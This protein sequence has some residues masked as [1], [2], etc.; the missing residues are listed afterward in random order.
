ML[1]RVTGIADNLSANTVITGQNG[2]VSSFNRMS[3]RLNGMPVVYAGNANISSDE[4]L[5]VVGERKGEFFA[6]ALR[7]DST[8]ISYPAPQRFLKGTAILFAIPIVCLVVVFVFLSFSP[9]GD[10]TFLIPAVLLA[11][12]LLFPHWMF[13]LYKRNKQANELLAA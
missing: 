9:Q 3:F 8:G 12:V 7:N 2:N 11:L 6:Y 5:T 1:E 4:T 13:R 10:P